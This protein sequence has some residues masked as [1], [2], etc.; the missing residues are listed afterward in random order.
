MS[1]LVAGGPRRLGPQ[2]SLAGDCSPPGFLCFQETVIVVFLKMFFFSV[3]N[4]LNS[5]TF[6]FS[7]FLI[8][9]QGYFSTVVTGGTQGGTGPLAPPELCFMCLTLK[10]EFEFSF[11]ET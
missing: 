4:Y 1:V 5:L 8:L 9:I 3:F 2:C 6:F 10:C 7:F 11:V